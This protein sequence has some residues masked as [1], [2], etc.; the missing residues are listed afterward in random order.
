MVVENLFSANHVPISFTELL[1]KFASMF[2]LTQSLQEK[3]K[4]KINRSTFHEDAMLLDIL[5]VAKC[6]FRRESDLESERVGQGA[7]L[8]PL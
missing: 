3:R 6:T 1:M 8:Q 5:Q 4:K 7:N 2:D